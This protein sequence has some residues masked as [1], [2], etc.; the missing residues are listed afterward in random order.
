LSRGCAKAERASFDDWKRQSAEVPVTSDG[1]A[2]PAYPRSLMHMGAAVP[3]ERSE[4]W[5]VLQPVAGTAFLDATGPYPFFVCGRWE[6]L[7][8]DV[9]AIAGR[10]ISLTLVTDPF[11]D[12]TQA[13]LSRTFTDLCREYKQHYVVALDRGAPRSLGEHHRRNI[14]LGLQ[15][16]SVETTEQASEWLPEWIALYENLIGRHGITG[17]A[18]FSPE[19]FAMQFAA[20]GMLVARAVC[21][22]SVVGMTVWAVTGDRAYYHLGAYSER[23]YEVRASYAMFSHVFEVLRS[24]GVRS[25]GLGAGAGARESSS[26]LERFKRGWATDTRTVF[27]CGQILQPAAYEQACR[28]RAVPAAEAFFPAYRAA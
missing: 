20:P 4:G 27:L 9:A 13:M 22:G 6:S 8:D 14:K 5:C 16:T 1:Y 19:S 24:K 7:P 12:V 11:A 2:G 3:M 15:K 26:G 21:E 10:A 25:V 28:S 18:L 17:P 23:G